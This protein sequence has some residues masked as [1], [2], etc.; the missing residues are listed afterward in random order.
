MKKVRICFEIEDMALDIETNEPR[1]AGVCLELGEVSDEQFAAVNYW[2]AV[3]QIDVKALLDKVWPLP[4]DPAKCRF[5][6]PEEYDEK[7]GDDE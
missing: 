3:A 5:L 4:V 2:D 7:Y 1:P 6:S